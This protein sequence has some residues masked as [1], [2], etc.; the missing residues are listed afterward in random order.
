ML[1][2]H[3]FH[4]A[5]LKS[6]THDILILIL[7]VNQ[8]G[9]VVRKVQRTLRKQKSKNKLIAWCNPVI[10]LRFLSRTTYQS[11]S[12]LSTAR[13]LL[14]LNSTTPLHVLRKSLQ[15]L[16]SRPYSLPHVIVM[17][18]PGIFRSLGRLLCS[19]LG[20]LSNPPSSTRSLIA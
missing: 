14:S 7:R 20:L 15:L 11:T 3:S 2:F 17:I 4:W 13:S 12:T 19:S 10:P 1:P 6:C 9:L 16:P 18:A 5:A 8:K